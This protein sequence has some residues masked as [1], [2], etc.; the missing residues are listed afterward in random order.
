MRRF[1]LLIPLS[2]ALLH[3]GAAGG[4]DYFQQ[5]VHYTIDVRLDTGSHMLTGTQ[6]IVYVNN[7]PDTLRQFFLHLYPNAFR[8]KNTSLMKDYLRRFNRSFIDL[9][10]KYRGYLD[11]YDVK[12]GG[13]DTTPVINETV[14][15]MTLP[16]PLA[17]GDSMEVTLRFEERVRRHIE[18]AGHRGGQY[19][20]AQWYPKVAVYDEKGFH[21]EVLRE[22][23][24]YGEFG[25]FDVTIEVPSDYVVAATGEPVD[26][27]PGWSLNP[28]ERAAR[29]AEGDRGST[30]KV[31][32]HADKVHDFAW[33]ASPRFAVQ[34]STWNGVE[35][36]SVFDSGNP[37]WK[38][39]TLAH[40]VRAI[41]FLSGLVGPYPYPRLTIV[42]G[43]MRG[44]SGME[45]PMLAMNGAASEELAVHETAHNWFYGALANDERAEAWLDEGFATYY[46]GRFILERY[47]DYG[48]TSDWNWYQRLTPQYTIA[49]QARRE[50][51]PLL[52][53]GYGERIATRSEDFKHD[54]YTA[55]YTRAALALNALRYVVGAGTFDRM[56]AAYYERWKFKHVNETR[57]REVCEEVSGENLGW[58]FEQWLHTRKICDYRLAEMTTEKNEKGD[59]Y[60]THVRIERKEEITMPLLLEFTFED[61]TRD[62]TSVSG[63]LRTI[64]QTFA[65][66]RKPRRVALNPDNEIVDINLSDNFLPR[67]YNLQIDWPN[68]DYYP[69]HAYQIRHR[70]FL[71]YNDID[72]VRAGYVLQG[73]R[74]GRHRPFEAGVYYGAD[75]HRLDYTARYRQ[76]SLI[77]GDRTDLSLSA[78]KLEGRNDASIEVLYWRRTKLSRPPTHRFSAGLN[79]HELRDVRYVGDPDRYE[80]RS[81]VAPCFRYRVG[82]EFDIFTSSF[83]LGLRFGREWFGGRYK[84][85]RFEGSTVLESRPELSPVDARLRF[86]LGIAD[87]SAPYQQKFYLAG[88]GP[89]AE[90]KVFF[91]R[92]PGAVPE[93]LN[94]HEGDHGNLRGY[95]A[96]DFGVNSLAAFNFE[97]ATGVPLLSG[98]LGGRIG[99]VAFS[100]VGWSFDSSNP[101]ETSAR[102]AGIFDAGVLEETIV[103]AGIG[104]TLDRP[105]PFWDVFLRVDFPFYVN[106]PVIN[107]E[108]KETDFRYVFSLSSSF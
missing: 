29:A 71:W 86:F 51:I 52:D 22:G 32:F 3:A 77:F 54:Y 80:T 55:V 95:L 45:Y 68:N 91:L 62:T 5:R 66:A 53:L 24:Y 69:E 58:F 59:G 46:T 1:L 48:N 84:Y 2:A 64:E 103:D 20:I 12:I 78:Y 90:E 7:S 15:E 72:G 107:G 39:S 85:T 50:V 97:I 102:V 30:R 9:P 38:D 16:R 93:D 14:A 75:S 74:Y 104:F 99:M 27:D 36:R 88:G 43:L 6:R 37:A 94:Y 96:G 98:I 87:K 56:V 63:R 105:L 92:S 67:R 21:A 81:D 101:I 25:V 73:S 83:D 26:G 108:T 31:R 100:D 49:A 8:S 60:L 44:R 19:D 61:G 42:Q 57:F 4:T 65:H 79:Y 33:S 89:L 10:Q 106:Q 34:D 70:P 82:P 76:P 35:V 13:A 41:E 40:G 17:P 28:P 11:I 47:G 18:R 23:E